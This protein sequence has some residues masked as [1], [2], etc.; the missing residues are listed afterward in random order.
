MDIFAVLT[1]LGG[2]A[3]FIFGMQQMG[4]GLEKASD[5][6]LENM[7]ERMASGRMRGVL[8]GAAVTAIIQ[9][10]SATTV[11]LVGFVNS[12]IMKLSQATPVIMGANI[13]T[14][15]TSWLL[16]LAGIEGDSIFLELLKPTSF[17]PVLA[18]I[19]VSMGMFS[20]NS[21]KKDLGGI[22][23]GFAILMFGMETMSG[24]V[25]P[26]AQEE[27]FRNI[28]LMFS[29]PLLGVLAGLLLTAVIQSSSASVGILQ[30]LSVTGSITWGAAIPIIMGQNIGTCAT[31]LL[32][33]IGA[34]KNA[35][36]VAMVHLYFNLIGTAVFL[37]VF[38]ILRATGAFTLFDQPISISGIALVHS[39]FN[40]ASTALL[41][42]FIRQLEWLAIKTIPD[43]QSKEENVLLDE[44]MLTSPAIALGRCGELTG[45]MAE[46]ARGSVLSAFDLMTNFNREQAQRIL[47]VEDEVDRYEDALG[48]FLVKLNK[49]SLSTAEG[50]D[51]SR[52]LHGIGEFER[53][54]DHA[55]NL[56]ETA[57]E[58]YDKK[59]SFTREAR[60]EA[61][62]LI[63]AVREILDISIRA[64]AE[65]DVPLAKWVEPLE[66]VIDGIIRELKL[67]HIERLRQERCTVETGFVF[68]DF[69]T[70][71][72]RI[73]DHCS[74][75]AVC[76]IELSQDEYN[77]HQ[78]IQRTGSMDE[79]NSLYRAAQMKYALP[80][81]SDV[82]GPR[83][84]E[85]KA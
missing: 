56:C 34:N 72:E 5:G 32:S 64:Y 77:A 66:E 76:V 9:S 52:I 48:S 70:N 39:S 17:S 75:L 68:A 74:N 79:F 25:K 33:C 36:R 45:Q 54:S 19:G 1:M 38:L 16:S 23:T 82:Y 12:G 57:Q 65:R 58:I 4:D 69:L 62:V 11:T 20:K 10:S 41:L 84:A 59:I 3:L 21:R 14:T 63:R 35:R 2:L 22:L 27:G 43:R 53:I 26:L 49:R 61:E 71:C 28:L 60:Q 37:T 24:A 67:R 85:Q 40:L 29:N 73:A 55:V 30:A 78:Y 50:R 15:M 80:D 8:L 42:P 83:A 47:A 13:G 6:K 31:A 7:L 46:Y 18:V 51:V 44:R 81:A